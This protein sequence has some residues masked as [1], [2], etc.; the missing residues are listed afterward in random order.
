MS[1]RG[2][3]ERVHRLQ[4]PGGRILLVA[5]DHGL[6]AGPLPGI[7]DPARFLRALRGAPVTGLIANPGIVRRLP[8]DVVPRRGLIVHL[9]AG[10]ILGAHPTSKVVASRPE[11]AAALGADAVSVQVHFGAD[12]EDAMLASA[13]R[14]ADDARAL[15]LPVLVMAYPA[16]RE[17]APPES[18]VVAHGARAAAEIGASLVQVPFPADPEA[19]ATVPRGC[20][21]PVLLA[22]GPRA[23]SEETFLRAL[24][25]AVAA[26]AAGVSVGRNLFQHPDP[27]VFA[28]RIA[29]VI[30]SAVPRAAVEA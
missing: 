28:R 25:A 8:R 11:D 19:F 9:S 7:E 21:A 18:A 20:P 13:G 2:V 4:G 10:T 26:G 22:G 1:S 5:L 30:G 29:D 15:G 27:A 3:T 14:V 12:D 24:E 16:G 23:A 6:P 17:G